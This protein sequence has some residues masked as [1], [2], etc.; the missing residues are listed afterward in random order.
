MVN[1]SRFSDQGQ[2]DL[3]VDDKVHD[4]GLMVKGS[5]TSQATARH[6]VACKARKS[7]TWLIPIFNTME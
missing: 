5:S 3:K 2:S 1:G 7:K 4:E 6:L